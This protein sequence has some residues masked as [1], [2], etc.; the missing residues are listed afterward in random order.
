MKI[1][2][3]SQLKIVIFTAVN[4]CSLL[5]ILNIVMAF[6]CLVI[7]VVENKHYQRYGEINGLL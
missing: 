4:N 6:S 2:K 5:N 7:S 1:I 3:H